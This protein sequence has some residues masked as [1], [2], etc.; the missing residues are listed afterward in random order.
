[1]VRAKGW[2][3]DGRN[4]D[5]LRTLFVAEAGELI[6]PK[7]GKPQPPAPL[8]AQAIDFDDPSDRRV[9]LANWMTDPSNPYFS[10]SISN[11]IWANF[12]GRGLVEQVDDL[13][14]SNPA[15]NEELLA[16]LSQHL[17]DVD[18]DLKQLMRTV[19]QSE[20]YQRSS[21]PLEGNQA[22]LRYH[23]RYYPKRLMAEVMLDSIDQVLGTTTSFNEIAFPGADK[24]KTDFYADGTRAIELYDASVNSYFLTTFGRNPREIT[25][26][27]ERSAEPSMVQVLHLSNGDTLNPK[28]ESDKNVITEAIAQGQSNETIIETLFVRA[29]SRKPQDDEMKELLSVLSEYG[30]E[31]RLT[32]LQD[33]AWS[34][35]TSTE[36]TFNH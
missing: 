15:S 12:L 26:E 35:L 33:V 29:L 7:R 28:L 23:S 25:C 24:Q 34:V 3:G 36:F 31:D 22:E 8:D 10:R 20:T 18:F 1:R 9:V 14:L 27:C 19:L 4:G 30:D 13:R 2:G 32:G 6:Q 11:R 21:A 5:G 16:R 17:V